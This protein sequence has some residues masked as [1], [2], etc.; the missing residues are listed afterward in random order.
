LL[1]ARAFDIFADGLDRLVRG[2]GDRKRRTIG[3]RLRRN[4][5]DPFSRLGN[6]TPDALHETMRAFDAGS[7]QIT[8]RSGGESDS[9]NQRAVSAP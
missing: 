6:Q 3:R 4:A 8:S 9:M 7:V 1:K 2:L 5:A